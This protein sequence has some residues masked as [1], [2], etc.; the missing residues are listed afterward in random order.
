MPFE[1]PLVMQLLND[2]EQFPFITLAPLEYESAL[3]GEIYTVP[4]YFRTDG[5]S[6]PAALVAVPVVGQALFLR[7][8]GQGVFQGFK[9][10]VLHD[11]LRRPDKATG[12]PPVPAKV[13]H[14]IF[15][16]ALTDSGYPDDLVSTYFAA[17][18]LFNSD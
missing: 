1:T 15:R 5:A 14:L 6:L 8:F 10:G 13:A 3:T 4:A 9:Q 2:R 12:L 16:E 11:W 18:K 7:Y 17:V